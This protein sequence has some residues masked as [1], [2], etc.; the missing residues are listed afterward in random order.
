MAPTYVPCVSASAA[1]TLIIIELKVCVRASTSRLDPLARSVVSKFP[2]CVISLSDRDSVSIGRDSDRAVH[3]LT[4]PAIPKAAIASQII[5]FSGLA[6]AG[7]TAP[8]IES[9]V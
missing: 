6:S 5:A 2:D 3:T 4:R 7:R 8:S 9:S 1:D